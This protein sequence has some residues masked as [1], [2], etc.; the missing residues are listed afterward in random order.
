MD[1]AATKILQI[2]AQLKPD[3]IST[4]KS[5]LIQIAQDILQRQPLQKGWRICYTKD[6]KIY[7]QN[8]IKKTTQWQR[9]SM[10]KQQPPNVTPKQI[11]SILNEIDETEE[12]NKTPQ[13]NDDKNE[14][15]ALW[16]E[17]IEGALYHPK[18][19]PGNRNYEDITKERWCK[20]F[21]KRIGSSHKR[22]LAPFMLDCQVNKA[23]L[24]KIFEGIP[25]D[26]M[27][28]DHIRLQNPIKSD[29][30]KM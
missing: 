10:P 29:I 21:K 22:L 5:Q 23:D 20:L 27:C 12:K 15:F 9:P 25:K 8:D 26:A 16:D 30:Q 14:L 18:L 1:K 11:D 7:F 28:G 6:N 17:A 3:N 24:E 19:K 13:N 4:S 2:A